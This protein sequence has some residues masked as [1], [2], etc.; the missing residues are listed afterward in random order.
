M[1]L[2]CIISQLDFSAGTRGADVC[3]SD[4]SVKAA[5]AVIPIAAGAVKT[6]TK[7]L[8]LLFSAIR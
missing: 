7:R 2:T 3:I 4:G 5:K 1:T 6:P 8:R